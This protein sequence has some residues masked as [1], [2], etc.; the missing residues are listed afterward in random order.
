MNDWEDIVCDARKYRD[1]SMTLSFDEFPD[2]HSPLPLKVI[3]IPQRLLSSSEL[4][5]ISMPIDGLLLSLSNGSIPAASVAHTF[6]RAASLAQ[7]LVLQSNLLLCFR[8]Y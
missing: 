6:L 1:Q 3:G 7:K 4:D 5:I 2:L 8:T